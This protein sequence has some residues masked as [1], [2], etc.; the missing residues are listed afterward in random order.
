MKLGLGLFW[1]ISKLSKNS[2]VW[3]QIEG[4]GMLEKIKAAIFQFHAHGD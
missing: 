1:A 4:I 2:R 3:C